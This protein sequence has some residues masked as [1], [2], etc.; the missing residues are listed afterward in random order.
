MKRF[1]FVSAAMLVGVLSLTSACAT[2]Y[3]QGVYRDRGPYDRGYGY[4][5]NIDRVAYDNGYREG[6][7]QGERDGRSRRRFDPTRNG[8][9]RSADNG[10]RREYGDKGFYRRNFRTGFEAGYSQGFRRFDRRW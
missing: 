4:N 9:W 6:L 5:R 10:Y 3:A 8:D 7:R 2:G 1:R